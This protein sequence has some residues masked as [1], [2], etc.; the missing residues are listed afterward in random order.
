MLRRNCSPVNGQQAVLF[1]SDMAAQEL[2]ST[3]LLHRST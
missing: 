3:F 2:F 1:Q